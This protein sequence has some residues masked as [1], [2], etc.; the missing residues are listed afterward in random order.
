MPQPPSEMH[1]YRVSV[2]VL[3]GGSIRHTQHKQIVPLP[4]M[5]TVSQPATPSPCDT[6]HDDKP[7]YPRLPDGLRFATPPKASSLLQRRFGTA[8]D[9]RV[10]VP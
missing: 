3:C 5:K 8:T 10:D 1:H 2:D 4:I 7:V 9:L 6:T